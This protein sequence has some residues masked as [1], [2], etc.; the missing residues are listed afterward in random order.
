M[1]ENDLFLYLNCDQSLHRSLFTAGNLKLSIKVFAI[2]MITK[3]WSKI[4]ETKVRK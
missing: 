4:N 2:F 3:H 1:T